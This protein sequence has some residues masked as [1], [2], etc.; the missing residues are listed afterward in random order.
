MTQPQ[1][2]G[3]CVNGL[4][5]EVVINIFILQL[6][7]HWIIKGAR[8]DTITNSI[9][10]SRLKELYPQM[11]VIWIKAVTLVYSSFKILMLDT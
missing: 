1:K 8:W 7:F 10:N 6:K 5:M 11:P 4:Y 9:A 2:E 3:A